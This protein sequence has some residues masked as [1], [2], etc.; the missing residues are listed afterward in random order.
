MILYT[1]GFTQKS[2]EQFFELLKTHR[3]QLLVD[4][5]LNNRSQ[6]A[7]F[8]K[9]TDL[10][11]FLRALCGCQYV[12]CTQ[13]AP[14][15]EIL[16]RYQKSRPHDWDA[17]VQAFLPLMRQRQAAQDFCRRFSG[18]EAVCLL[19]SEPTAEHCHRRLL[20]EL[21]AEQD[22]TIQICHL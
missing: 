1:I 17:Y 14:T 11:Y 15:K 2:A 10:E 16:A 13:Y 22:P 6:L 8:T 5:R 9:G 21:I 18:Y 4:I 7:G 20:A 19:C 12:H 3:V